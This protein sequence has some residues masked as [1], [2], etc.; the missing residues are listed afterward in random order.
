MTKT[1]VAMIGLGLAVALAAGQDKGQAPPAGQAGTTQKPA[2][3]E[4]PKVTAETAT[5][6]LDFTMQDIDGHDVDLGRYK[7]QVV[8]IVNVASKCGFTPQYQQL[9]E[10]YDKYRDRGLRILAFPAN[11]FKEQEPG[12]NAEIKTFCQTNYK[13][14][15]DL[16]A[17]VSVRGADTCELYKFL[18]S[19]QKNGDYGG[20]IAWNFT[21]FLVGRD[22]EAID[23]FIPK[24][25]PDAP[26]LTKAVEAALAAK[27]PE[28]TG[29]EPDKP[30]KTPEKSD[31]APEKPGEPA[32]KPAK[33]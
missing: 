6:P 11:N 18:T 33:Q 12:T 17:K 9:Q 15:F 1:L 21:K 23:R 7:G 25:P 20:D 14:T 32:S 4:K 26:F 30:G 28:K 3:G 8:L 10:L 31:K 13:V 2:A 27:A 22:G 16:F 29:K 19:Q 5:S 24:V